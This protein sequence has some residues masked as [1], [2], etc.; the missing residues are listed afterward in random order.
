MV[1]QGEVA[2]AGFASKQ[3]FGR[4]SKNNSI[5]QAVN[6]KGGRDAARLWDAQTRILHWINVVAVILL[7]FTGGMIMFS[8]ILHMGARPT[9]VMLKTLHAIVGYVVVGGLALRL[10]WGFIGS[11]PSRWRAVLPNRGVRRQFRRDFIGIIA[12][13]PDASV[14]RLLF[15]RVV[16]TTIFAVLF[17]MAATGIFRAATDLYHP[18]FGA[19]FANY[20]ASPGVDPAMLQPMDPAGA[21]PARW[22][23]LMKFKTAVIG[24]IHE[25]GAYVLLTLAAL[26]IVGAIMTEAKSGGAVIGPMFT[27]LRPLPRKAKESHSADA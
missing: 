19:V 14:A 10:L 27:G 18:P 23:L 8:H 22:R 7:A 12:R 9:E 24:K 25:W 2:F 26:H 15:S 20:L 16:T 11:P 21:D 1:N 6:H 3:L 17:M 4:M 5:G 13:R